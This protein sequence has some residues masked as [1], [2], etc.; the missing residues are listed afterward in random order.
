MSTKE[1]YKIELP[2]GDV[3]VFPSLYTRSKFI[4][5]NTHLFE[6]LPLLEVEPPAIQGTRPYHDSEMV[7]EMHDAINPDHYKNRKY[8]VFDVMRD[9]QGRERHIGYLE[10]CMIKY[11]MRWDK[12]GNTVEEHVQDIKKVIRYGEQLIKTI[13]EEQQYAMASDE[14]SV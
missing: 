1:K 7:Q 4:M 10:G 8:E 5:E 9:T 6:E 13:E 12:K 11:I 3:H 2:N 14:R